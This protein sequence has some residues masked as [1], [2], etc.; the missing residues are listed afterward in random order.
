VE[1]K[2]I[3]NSFGFELGN[4]S[5]VEFRRSKLQSALDEIDERAAWLAREPIGRNYDVSSFKE[6]LPVVVTPFK[7]FIWSLAPSYWITDQLPRVMTTT[8]LH[9]ALKE[10]VFEWANLNAVQIAAS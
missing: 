9:D 4:P 5:S 6:V 8:E 10:Q 1:C 3:G 7:E 2:A